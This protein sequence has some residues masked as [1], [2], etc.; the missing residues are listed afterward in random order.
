MSCK[1]R[2]EKSGLQVSNG[3]QN[4]PYYRNYGCACIAMEDSLLVRFY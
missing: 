1:I 2:L 3:N 4:A